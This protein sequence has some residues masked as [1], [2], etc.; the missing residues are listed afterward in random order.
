MSLESLPQR[1]PESRRHWLAHT[2]REAIARGEIRPGTRLV[3]RDIS[4]RTG[5]SRGPV[6]EALLQLENEGLLVSRSYRGAEVVAVSEDEIEEVLIPTRAVLERFAFRHA[7]PRLTDDDYA[8]LE[9]LV[10]VLENA[11]ETGDRLSIVEADV[12]FHELV[13]IRS[14]KPHCEQLWR[15]IVPRVRAFFYDEAPRHRSLRNVAVMHRT[16]LE[17]LRHDDEDALLA[18]VDRHVRERPS[19]GGYGTPP[20]E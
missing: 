16:L 2:L 18:E 14:E 6:R 9:G 11:A 17:A 20:Q 10:E 3:E 13:I 19:F 7:R 1:P 12:K 8:K 5:V 15:T 4:A